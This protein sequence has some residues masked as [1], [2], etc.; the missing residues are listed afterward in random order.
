[1]SFKKGD[2]NCPRCGEH[3][4]ASRDECYKCKTRKPQEN[5]KKKGDWDCSC[6]GM[7]FASRLACHKCGKN[8]IDNSPAIIRAQ[9]GDWHCG[10]GEM[11]FGTRTVCRKCGKS[12]EPEKSTDID[13]KICFESPSDT[14]LN[15]C[16]H[17]AMC[18]GCATK[19]T[20]CPICRLP[21]TPADIQRVYLA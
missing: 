1:M 13:C 9:P 6:G 7:N 15:T 10:C 21:Y 20:S 19:L 4:F 11:N 2:W 14:R 17:V 5:I 12:N 18:R 8:K 16:G 3:C